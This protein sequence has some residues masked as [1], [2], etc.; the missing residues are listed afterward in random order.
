MVASLSS[1]TEFLFLWSSRIK[2]G[3]VGSLT[4]VLCRDKLRRLALDN[5]DMKGVINI[6]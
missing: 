2:D 5:S 6:F 4:V 1:S 3:N